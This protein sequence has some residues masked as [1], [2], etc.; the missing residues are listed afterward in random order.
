MHDAKTDFHDKLF[1]SE[2]RSYYGARDLK[3]LDECRTVAN[4]GWL[5]KFTPTSLT[6]YRR[7]SPI[8]KDTLAEV[9]ISK[10]YTRTFMRIRAAPVFNEFDVW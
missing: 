4:V 6:R 3:I 7:P 1:K 5:R 9:D 10:A 8:D 2:H